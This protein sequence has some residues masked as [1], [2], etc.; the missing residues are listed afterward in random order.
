[1]GTK[2]RLLCIFKQHDITLSP[3]TVKT[4]RKTGKNQNSVKKKVR[5]E[6]VEAN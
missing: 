2:G 5:E 4:I 6:S 3:M 1:M